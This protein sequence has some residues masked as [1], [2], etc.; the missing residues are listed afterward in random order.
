MVEILNDKPLLELA[1]Q[2]AEKLLQEDADLNMAKNLQLKLFL[3]QQK[4]KTNWSKIS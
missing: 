3:Q 4:G 1:K 2:E